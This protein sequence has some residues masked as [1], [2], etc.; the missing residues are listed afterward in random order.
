MNRAIHTCFCRVPIRKFNIG[1]RT[2]LW[3][4]TM[5]DI[6]NEPNYVQP[7]IAYVTPFTDY[8]VGTPT[9]KMFW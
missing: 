4:T 3:W 9:T 8:T 6:R 2:S 5:I 1:I 7:T